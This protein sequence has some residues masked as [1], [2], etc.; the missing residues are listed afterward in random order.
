MKIDSPRFGTLQVAPDRIIEFPCGI[1]GFE[2]LRRFPRFLAF[3]R[4]RHLDLRTLL[5]L[6]VS[7]ALW[8]AR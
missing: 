8:L 2:D 3:R 1:P 4:A 6:L 5:P 7:Y